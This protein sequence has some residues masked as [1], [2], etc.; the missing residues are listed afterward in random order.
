MLWSCICK[1]CSQARS[2]KQEAEVNLLKTPEAAT[3]AVLL[4]MVLLKISIILEESTNATLLKRNSSTVKFA[5]S[6]RTFILN[7]ISKRLHL[8]RIKNEFI[9][10]G[11]K[12]IAYSKKRKLC[13]NNTRLCT[14][15]FFYFFNIIVFYNSYECTL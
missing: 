13:C 10:I 7:N 2:E 5:K 8:T 11:Y 6:L 15:D 14:Y 9:C 4:K 1:F 3:G 12:I